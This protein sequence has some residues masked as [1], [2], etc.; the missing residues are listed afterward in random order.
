MKLNR[1]PLLGILAF[2][3]VLFTMPLGHALMIL[4]QQILGETYQFVGAVILGVLGTAALA[5]SV[6]VQGESWRTSLG[7]F[8]G[9]FLWTGFVEFSFVYYAI[10]LGVPPVM[11]GDEIATKPEYLVMPSSLGILASLMVCFLFNGQTRCNFFLWFRRRLGMHIPFTSTSKTKNYAVITALETIFI[12]W[13]FYLLM[14]IVYDFGDREWPTWAM[15]FGCLF[16]S[17]FLIH[18]LLKKVKFGPAIRY[19]VPT[20]IVFWT[21]V[22]VLGRWGF[23]TEFWSEPMDHLPELGLIVAA[24][25]GAG[26]L[27]RFL[28]SKEEE[29]QTEE[30]LSS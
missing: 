18:R 23:F 11:E 2:L 17:L 20:V 8:S 29:A 9:I 15:F 7:L 14:M 22:E 13:A 4:V 27:I 12:L 28:P 21:S 10:K 1:K 16:W 6:R 5:V 30:P 19:A 24:L 25:V 26:V 3:I